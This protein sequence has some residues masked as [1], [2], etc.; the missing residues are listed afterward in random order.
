MLNEQEGALNQQTRAETNA[1]RLEFVRTEIDAAVAFIRLAETER[2]FDE[3]ASAMTLLEKADRACEVASWHI[4]Q[5][6]LYRQTVDNLASDVHA[7]RQEI[8]R[9][10]T[11]P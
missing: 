8:S 3:V 5:A 4:G 9:L 11:Q 1:A 7:L 10:R 6:R 2:R